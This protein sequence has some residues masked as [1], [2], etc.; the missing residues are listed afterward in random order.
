MMTNS[1]GTL[2]YALK[3]QGNQVLICERHEDYELKKTYLRDS[4]KK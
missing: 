1:C 2:K 3:A 4:I